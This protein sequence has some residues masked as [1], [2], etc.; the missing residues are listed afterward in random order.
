MYLLP[1]HTVDFGI[2]VFPFTESTLKAKSRST[3]DKAASPCVTKKDDCFILKAKSHT[4]QG[5]VA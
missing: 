1:A 2:N 5:K 3:Q 4:T